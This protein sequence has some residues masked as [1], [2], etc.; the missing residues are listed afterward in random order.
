MRNVGL[1]FLVKGND[2]RLGKVID[3]A[4][5]VPAPV[6]SHLIMGVCYVGIEAVKGV[7]SL[8]I[9]PSLWSLRY[10]FPGLIAGDS[11]D[12]TAPLEESPSPDSLEAVEVC[13]PT[14]LR[15]CKFKCVGVYMAS[16]LRHICNL[17]WDITCKDEVG[18][19]DRN[20]SMVGRSR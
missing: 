7:C 18:N 16:S 6:G 12:K 2:P 5:L 20:F 4:Q 9:A 19:C 13:I 1:G 11:S 14:W 10:P 15:L 8:F 3:R 17:A